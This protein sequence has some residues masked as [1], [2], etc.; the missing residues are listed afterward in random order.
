M[1]IFKIGFQYNNWNEKDYIFSE[2]KRLVKM[3]FLTK[4]HIVLNFQEILN[5]FSGIMH[6]ARE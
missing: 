4:N 1:H 2:N 6:N 5:R 3:P